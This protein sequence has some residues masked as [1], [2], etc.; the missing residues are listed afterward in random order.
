MLPRD[1]DKNPF[2]KFNEV[3]IC[4]GERHRRLPARVLSIEHPPPSTTENSEKSYQGTLPK[5]PSHVNLISEFNG[6]RWV[7]ASLS[8]D[9]D[10]TPAVRQEAYN[11]SE[12]PTSEEIVNLQGQAHKLFIDLFFVHLCRR[13]SWTSICLEVRWKFGFGKHSLQRCMPRFPVHGPEK[14]PNDI[15]FL[16]LRQTFLVTRLGWGLTKRNILKGGDGEELVDFKAWLERNYPHLEIKFNKHKRLGYSYLVS[17]IF[18]Q[19]LVTGIL[20]GLTRFK[21]GTPSHAAWLLI[22][23]YGG[24][25]LRWKWLNDD[26]MDKGPCRSTLKWIV[27]GVGPV[28][29]VVVAIGVYGGIAVIIV[30]LLGEICSERF[31][32]SPGIWILI[33]ISIALAFAVV[34]APIMYSRNLIG[35]LLCFLCSLC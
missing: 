28:L 25:L 24:P 21:L 3:H 1:K 32:L 14:A 35:M 26:T 8:A 34:S 11:K 17:G 33:G 4:K 23:M 22:W 7:K 9:Q 29:L 2:P 31:S 15:S 13:E 19:L 30:E 5:F 18:L 12:E 16:F 20:G 6:Q 10:T 27:F